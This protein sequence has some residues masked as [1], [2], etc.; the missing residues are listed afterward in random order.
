MVMLSSIHL[1][2]C[3]AAAAVPAIVA[4]RRDHSHA[5]AMHVQAMAALAS[6]DRR[7]E[8]PLGNASAT[9]VGSPRRANASLPMDS[10][11][12]S[13]TARRIARLTPIALH[14]VP[15]TTAEAGLIVS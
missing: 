11:P 2:P 12:E 7:S 13:P 5:A 8:T 10:C 1:A 9:D 15:K 3:R 6:V 14:C 4:S